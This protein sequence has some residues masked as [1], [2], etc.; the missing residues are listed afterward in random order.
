MERHIK[1][2]LA[3]TAIEVANGLFKSLSPTQ[4]LAVLEM[5]KILINEYKGI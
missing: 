3:K 2:D 5:T 4:A 1:S